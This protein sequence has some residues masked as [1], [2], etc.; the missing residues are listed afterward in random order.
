MAVRKPMRIVDGLSE[1][2]WKSLAVKALRIGWAPGLRKCAETIAPSTVKAML[3]CGLFEDTFMTEGDVRHCIHLVNTQSWDA[4]C[5]FDTHHGRGYTDQFCA[6][7]D[8]AK[9][10]A[11]T[12]D[13]SLFATARQYGIWLQPRMMNVLYTWREVAPTRGGQ[14]EVDQ[15]PWSGM[16]VCMADKHTPEGRGRVTVL[17]GTYDQHAAIGARVMR[18]G[19]AGLRAEVHA[20]I[21]RGTGPE[22]A[23]L[24]L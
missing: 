3:L 4:L 20:D 13:P 10:A 18:E 8:A 17:S 7:R 15:T 12:R 21:M 1:S 14:R 23:A 9:S 24:A 11:T 5:A 22:Q 16:P 19:W 2:L 6:L